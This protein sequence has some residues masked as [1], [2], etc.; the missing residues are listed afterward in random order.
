M[1]LSNNTSKFFS[2]LLAL[3]IGSASSFAAVDETMKA[4]KE[5][6]KTTSDATTLTA[7]S[8]ELIQ[9][10]QNIELTTQNGNSIYLPRI[11]KVLVDQ[12]NSALSP[13]NLAFHE[14][15]SV[16]TV[17][18]QAKLI[19]QQE[20]KELSEVLGVRIKDAKNL[21][22]YREVADWLGTRYRRGSM[23]RKG[24]DCSGFTNIIYNTVFDKKISRVSTQIAKDVKE[25]LPKDELE[26]GDLVFF[27]TFGKKYIN[28]VGVY[29]GDG[30]FAHASIKKG[31]IVS[32]LIEGYYS[33][34]WRKGG[35]LD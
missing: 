16:G 29:L 34:T 30:L 2:L 25:S 21:D 35:R 10:S 12:P 27:S 31:V 22:L 3:L 4:P 5:K 24:V 9:S 23:S 28:H 15:M 14:E 32:S 33:K 8:L 11:D 17:A 13:T 6:K 19:E 26:P 18:L 1:S 7:K 20:I